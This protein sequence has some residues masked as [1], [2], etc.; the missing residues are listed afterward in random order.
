MGIYGCQWVIVQVLWEEGELFSA[1]TK[2]LKTEIT[3]AYLA[4]PS[5]NFPN[6][7][8]TRELGSL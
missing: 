4:D 5:P 7:E 3:T 6:I 8:K 2:K 1:L